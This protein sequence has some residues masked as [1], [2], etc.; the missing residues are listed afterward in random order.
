MHCAGPGR[1]HGVRVSSGDVRADRARAA[2]ALQDAEDQETDCAPD[3]PRSGRAAL[4]VHEHGGVLS[5]ATI[6]EG[7]ST[8][9]R[10]A[11]RW[12]RL[13]AA[14]G[15]LTSRHGPGGGYT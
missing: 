15:W 13:A 4:Y 2:A 14:E 6:A 5:G 10:T 3:H 9:P 1:R 12:C 7:L 8:S 11:A